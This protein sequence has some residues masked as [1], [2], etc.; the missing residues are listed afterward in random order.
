MT[1]TTIHLGILR[2]AQRIS[3]L[4]GSYGKR[5]PL[6][7]SLCWI[8]LSLNVEAQIPLAEGT[9]ASGK[10]AFSEASKPK[11]PLRELCLA[12]RLPNHQEFNF[13]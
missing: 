5:L 13:L 3:S 4:Q 9:I 1:H 8:M 10:Q 12:I 11:F 7:I 6:W 2:P